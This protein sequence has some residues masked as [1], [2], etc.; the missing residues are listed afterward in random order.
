MTKTLK[1]RIVSVAAAAAALLLVAGCGQTARAH[2]A[3]RYGPGPNSGSVAAAPPAIAAAEAQAHASPAAGGPSASQPKSPQ[4]KPTPVYPQTLGTPVPMTATL[5]AKCVT[6]GS[7]QTLTIRTGGG[8]S[9]SFNT[10]YADGNN[11]KYVGGWGYG[12]VPPNGVVISTWVVGND[13]AY[14]TATVFAAAVA[15]NGANSFRQPTFTVAQ[16]C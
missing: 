9:Y 5:A 12:V 10:Q 13:A 1:S 8:Y 15:G 3:P 16:S 11:G 4:A 2:G 7:T 6:R 14:G